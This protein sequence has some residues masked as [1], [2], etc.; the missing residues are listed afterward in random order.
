M[1][2]LFGPFRLYSSLAIVVLGVV[3]LSSPIRASPSPNP[4]AGMGTLLPPGWELCVL[5]GIGAPGT[6][7]DVA[8]LDAWQVVEGGSTNNTAAYNP[9]NTR[10]VTDL[11]GAPLPVAISSDGFPAFA[12]WAAGCAATVATL[13]QPSMA[14]I[15]TALKAGAVSPPGIFLSDVDQSPWCA[16][17]AD[18]IPCYASQILAGELLGALLDGSSSQLRGALTSYSNT[19]S[20]LRSYEE[21]AT[22]TAADQDLLAA[23]DKQLALTE[24]DVSVAM[25]ELSGATRALRRLALD[26]YTSD[27]GVR[28]HASLQLFDPPDERE[29]VAQYLANT[30]ASLLAVRYDQAEA[31]VKTSISKRRAANASVAQATSLLD[32]AQAAENQ[33]LSGLEADVK[34]VEAGLSCAPPPLVTAAASPF[35]SQGSAGQVWAALQDCLAPPTQF[36]AP[37]TGSAP[38]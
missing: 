10:H 29:L 34:S 14:P 21:D 13:L 6:E 12:T 5:N 18:G 3:G 33:A 27:T 37:T 31:D 36:G 35:G 32:S 8:N 16:P 38:S 25:G 7:D 22:L 11:K 23:K 20:N 24:R 15:V 1:S 19:G 28:S 9:F 2:R 26:D 17:S 4:G 30:A